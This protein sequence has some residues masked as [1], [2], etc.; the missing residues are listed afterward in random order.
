MIR[1]L[2]SKLTMVAIVSGTIFLNLFFHQKIIS[3]QEDDWFLFNIKLIDESEL[4][5]VAIKNEKIKIA[6]NYGELHIPLNKVEHIIFS[7]RDHPEHAEKA[8]VLLNKLGSKNYKER[9]EAEKKLKSIIRFSYFTIIRYKNKCDDLEV[10]NRIN[11]ILKEAILPNE[12]IN[13]DIIFIK[14]D[15]KI[16][17]KIVDEII[18]ICNETLGNLNLHISLVEKITKCDQNQLVST[19]APYNLINYSGKE[20]TV[21][22]FNIIAPDK[23]PEV[24]EYGHHGIWGTDVYTLD[25][26]LV[27]A[28]IHAGAIKLGEIRTVNIKIVK[29]PNLFIGSERNGVKSYQFTPSSP[30]YNCG[31]TFVKK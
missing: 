25:S 28:A 8:V 2:L 14:P 22:R 30:I 4:K 29:A 11:T 7:R 26:N 19:I 16:C 17:G 12:D 23:V 24:N 13:Y 1:N 5:L 18:E 15:S 6:T 20:G 21:L 9:E 27:L 31:F 3:K 10:V